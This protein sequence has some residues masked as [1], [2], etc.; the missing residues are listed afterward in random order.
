MNKGRP[1]IGKRLEE[2]TFQC[3]PLTLVLNSYYHLWAS[4][5]YWG[6]CL[7]FDT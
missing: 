6:P 5:C 4:K 3:V 7:I 1:L 2:L